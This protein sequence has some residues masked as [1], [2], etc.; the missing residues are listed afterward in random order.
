MINIAGEKL[1]KK[2]ETLR[3]HAYRDIPGIGRWTIGWGHTSDNFYPV[4]EGS[5]ID[6][7]EAE[8]IFKHD[9][10]E[11]EQIVWAQVKVPLNKNQYAA[12]VSIAFNSGSFKKFGISSKLLKAINK[13]NFLSAA[14]LIR[15]Y[16][17]RSKGRVL[18]GLINRRA[19][20]ANLFTCPV[21]I[22]MD[23]AKP[24]PMEL[25]KNGN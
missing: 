3:L 8:I 10:R 9:V 15:D 17:T 1:I 14:M 21:M 4:Y 20:E 22:K 16:K 6:R 5:E 12:L 11:A 2:R 23:E 13:K 24:K 25:I 18:Q 7:A 19:D